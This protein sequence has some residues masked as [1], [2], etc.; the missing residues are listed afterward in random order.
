MADVRSPSWVHR[1]GGKSILAAGLHVLGLAI[2]LPGV[3]LAALML[4]DWTRP[5]TDWRDLL[6]GPK[7]GLGWLGLTILAI[8]LLIYFSL[9]LL[10]RRIR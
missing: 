4:E 7:S 3:L 6:F 10:A 9:A 1:L 8:A 5:A 2:A